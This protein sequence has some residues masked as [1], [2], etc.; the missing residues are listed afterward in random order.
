[1]IVNLICYPFRRTIQMAVRYLHSA[2]LPSGGW[3]GSWGICFTYASQFALESLALVGET[4][5]TSEHS[6]RAC[7]FLLSKQ[8]NNGGWG[9]SYKSCEQNTWVEHEESQVVQT[10][11]AVL[12]LIYARYPHPEPIEKGVKFVMSRQLPVSLLCSWLRPAHGWHVRMVRGLRRRSKGFSTKPVRFLIQTS[13]L[14]FL[15]GC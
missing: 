15:F 5:Q 8:R 6:R 11:W 9:E 14:P 10:A 13:N 3:I 7:I 1:M 12:S 4:Y 2:Q